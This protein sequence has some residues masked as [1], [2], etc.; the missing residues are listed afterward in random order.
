LISTEAGNQ[1]ADLT[2]AVQDLERVAVCCSEILKRNAH[3]LADLIS[4]ALFDSAIVRY[5][6][7]FTRGQRFPLK[8]FLSRLTRA[9]RELH[10]FVLGLRNRYLAHSENEFEMMG[11]TIHIAPS[12][13]GKVVRGGLGL[14]GGGTLGVGL[15]EI[16]RFQGLAERLNKLVRIKIED[17]GAVVKTHIDSLSDQDL[18]ALDDGFAPMPANVDVNKRR[19]WPPKDRKKIRAK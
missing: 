8:S 1:R 10:D 19:A 7:C 2:L 15:D 6:R 12:E 16:A 3:P 11:T 5:G 4:G 13:D 14:T 9:E 17:L 18:L